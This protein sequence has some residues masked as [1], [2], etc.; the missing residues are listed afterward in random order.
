[1]L[2]VRDLSVSY[3]PARIVERVSL[4]VGPGRTE[5]I[6]GPTG[7]GKTTLLLTIA[8]LKAAQEGTV[9]LDGSSIVPGDRRVALVLQDHGLFPWL[10]VRANAGLG[11]KLRGVPAPQ[12]ARRVEAELTRM[13]LSAAAG[14]FPAQLSGGQRQRVAVARSFVLGPDLLLLD[15]PFSSVDALA[16]E[17]LQEFLL[18]ALDERRLACIL[19]THDIGEAVLLGSEVSV[20][21]GSPARI[22]RRFDNPG[23]GAPGHRRSDAFQS[24]CADIRD[25]LAEWRVL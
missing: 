3:G 5:C 2:D 18:S 20:L 17:T 1:M 15:E 23:Q 12:R 21:A 11:L 8:G 24:L 6:V 9:D 10:T 22:V 19:V 25:A 4:Q 14:R 16:R 7:C 13:G